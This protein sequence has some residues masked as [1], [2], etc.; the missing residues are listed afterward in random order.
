MINLA[1]SDY[2]LDSDDSDG[3]FGGGLEYGGGLGAASGNSGAI[4]RGDSN[5]K[6][7]KAVGSGGLGA[8]SGNSGAINRGDSNIKQGKA[9]GSGGLGR[10][11][12]GNSGA[13]KRSGSSGKSLGSTSKVGGGKSSS[14]REKKSRSAPVFVFR[15]FGEPVSGTFK[16]SKTES[17]D[18]ETAKKLPAKVTTWRAM[19]NGFDWTPELSSDFSDQ[20]CSDAAFSSSMGATTQGYL[21]DSDETAVAFS[22]NCEIRYDAPDRTGR[23]LKRETV[24]LTIPNTLESEAWFQDPPTPDYVGASP[25]NFHTVKNPQ[26]GTT[27]W[28][29]PL[30]ILP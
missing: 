4:N 5:I 2:Y 23:E 15:E 13:I 1:G 3:Q 7:G 29:E 12:S 21:R 19:L 20:Y 10:G 11:P 24:E 18:L 16:L 8:A 9:V 14:S 26:R 6:Q 22:D 25:S 17:F 28:P 30:I 27:V